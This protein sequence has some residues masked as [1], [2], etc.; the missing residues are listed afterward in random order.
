MITIRLTEELHT[1]LMAV[2]GI[3]K[4]SMNEWCVR[5]LA[6]AVG[7]TVVSPF[8]L[9]TDTIDKLVRLREECFRFSSDE[10]NSVSFK[11]GPNL[12]SGT[13]HFTIYAAT[14]TRGKQDFES[15]DQA[16]SIVQALTEKTKKTE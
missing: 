9:T 11:I 12:T 3:A 2:A 8:S 14:R 4:I 15:L 5:E 16:I 13:V 6:R 7:L 1:K 10:R